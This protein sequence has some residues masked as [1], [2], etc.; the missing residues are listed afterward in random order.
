MFYFMRQEQAEV[1]LQLISRDLLPFCYAMPAA[2]YPSH[3][4]L[5]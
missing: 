5:L 3:P 1:A 4:V 2:N